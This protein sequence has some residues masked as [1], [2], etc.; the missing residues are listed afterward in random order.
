M[1]DTESRDERTSAK[2][3]ARSRIARA[4]RTPVKQQGSLETH[5]RS[6]LIQ[7]KNDE[8]DT[9]EEK[10]IEPFKFDVPSGEPSF[11]FG[12]NSA[13]ERELKEII[14]FLNP[15]KT[16]LH[17]YQ[18]Q[19]PS[20]YVFKCMDGDIQIPEYGILKTDFYYKEWM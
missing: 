14:F 10:R 5:E 2:G 1:A 18:E 17:D 16:A 11:S 3:T 6:S 4:R 20:K 13:S 19:K 8:K 15:C 7:K 9:T 12:Q